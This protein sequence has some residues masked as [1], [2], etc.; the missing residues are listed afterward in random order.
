MDKIKN[1]AGE[2]KKSENTVFLLIYERKLHE[3]SIS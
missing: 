2:Y 1:L 3:G